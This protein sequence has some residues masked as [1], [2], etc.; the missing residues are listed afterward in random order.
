MRWVEEPKKLGELPS[1]PIAHNGRKSTR[2][3]AS[4]SWDWSHSS[5]LSLT[6]T[7][8]LDQGYSRRVNWLW[9]KC[10]CRS[11]H[12]KLLPFG[13]GMIKGI[14][15]VLTAVEQCSTTIWRGFQLD[16]QSKM[17]FL[18]RGTPKLDGN[19]RDRAKRDQWIE[20]RGSLGLEMQDVQ[21]GTHYLY[22]SKISPLTVPFLPIRLQHCCPKKGLEGEILK[23]T[24]R[25]SGLTPLY[26]VQ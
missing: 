10:L 25:R 2:S 22:V 16:V 17:Y 3:N 21:T 19:W 12:A 6:E 23:A 14:M 9:V 15:G 8:G 13:I 4:R 7:Q 11:V 20:G 1:S 18:Q 26:P 24:A 5:L